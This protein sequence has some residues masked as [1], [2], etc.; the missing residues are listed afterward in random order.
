MPGATIRTTAY[1]FRFTSLNRGD[2]MDGE[3]SR[4][5]KTQSLRIGRFLRAVFHAARQPRDLT[6]LLTFITFIMCETSRATSFQ[7]FRRT[8]RVIRDPRLPR[9]KNYITAEL[10]LSTA[11]SLFSSGDKFKF[12]SVNNKCEPFHVI[13]MMQRLTVRTALPRRYRVH[14]RRS[15]R[16]NFWAL[17]SI[18][19]Y[20]I[21]RGFNLAAQ[22]HNI[23]SNSSQVPVRRNWRTIQNR[24]TP[25]RPCSVTRF[26]SFFFQLQLQTKF[27]V[28]KIKSVHCRVF[29][30]VGKLRDS[31]VRQPLFI[32]GNQREWEKWKRR[33]P[34]CEAYRYN[35]RGEHKLLPK[36]IDR[37]RPVY[38]NIRFP[39]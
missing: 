26:F 13:C 17:Y 22:S 24:V 18:R 38:P 10:N 3:T 21:T 37:Y 4:D 6:P 1:S 34:F 12:L 7:E 35:H 19:E 25:I 36:I 14:K 5:K 11:V 32:D 28:P 9:I 23:E 27:D 39:I 33:E 8:Q 15:V 31:S 29:G 20:E 30:V 2:D 16:R